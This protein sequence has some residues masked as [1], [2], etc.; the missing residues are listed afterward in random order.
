MAVLNG[1]L[2][3]GWVDSQ[4]TDTGVFT[5]S[6]TPTQLWFP[7]LVNNMQNGGLYETSGCVPDEVRAADASG[8]PSF[9]ASSTTVTLSAT[10]LN[11][12][13]DSLCTQA[14]PGNQVTIAPGDSGAHFFFMVT[15]GNVFTISGSATGL[16]GTQSVSNP[17]DDVWVGGA[18]CDGNWNTNACWSKNNKPQAYQTA[19][20]SGALCSTQ[21]SAAINTNNLNGMNNILLESDYTG[22]VTQVNG[23]S[24]TINGLLEVDGGTF[25]MSTSSSDSFTMNSLLVAGTGTFN[26]GSGT[27]NLNN[28]FVQS[29]GS[30]TSTSGTLSVDGNFTIVGSPTFNANSGTMNFS[31]SQNFASPTA[32]P[33]SI[34]LNN[35]VFSGQNWTTLTISGTM[36]VIGSLTESVS[37]LGGNVNGGTVALVGGGTQTISDTT[38]AGMGGGNVTI[39]INNTGTVTASTGFGSGYLTMQAG[40]FSGGSGTI[41][42][43]KDFSLSG[44]SFT[45]TSGTFNAGGS[46]TV[47]GSP[48]FNANGGT[49]AFSTVQSNGNVTLTPGSISLNNV[50]FNGDSWTS[51][52]IT[53]TLNVAGDATI[54][55][56]SCCSGAVTGGTLSVAGNFT[57][58][59]NTG[60]TTALT[61]TGGGAQTLT[62]TAGTFLSGNI[63]VNKTAGSTL[64]LSG[65]LALATA[66]ALNITSG[67]FNLNGNSITKV[68]SVTIGDTL[69]M[70]SGSITTRGS[71]TNNGTFNAG[72]GTVTFSGSGAPTIGGTSAT[73]FNNVTFNKSGV[74][75][76]LGN[77]ITATGNV[78]ITAGTLA[79]AGYG[80]T[81]YG[82][83]NNAGTFTP[84]GDTVTLPSGSGITRTIVGSTTFYNLTMDDSGDTFSDVLIFPAG[85]TQTVTNALVLK[86]NASHN[87]KIRSSTPGT[88]WK[89]NPQ[90]TST[91]SDVDVQDSDNINATAITADSASVDAGNN[92]NWTFPS[93]ITWIGGTVGTNGCDGN[94]TTTSCWAGGVLPGATTTAVFKSGCTSNCSPTLNANITVGGILMTSSYTGTLTQQGANTLTINQDFGQYAGTFTGGSAGLTE[95]GH[96]TLAGGTFTDTITF[97]GSQT[98]L[99]SI[100]GGTLSA[101]S[102]ITVNKAV[103][104]VLRLLNNVTL[105]GQTVNILSGIFNSYGHNLTGT[106]NLTITDTLQVQGGETFTTASTTFNSVSTV[107]YN[108]SGNYS[109]NNLILGNAYSNLT[110]AGGQA[111]QWAFTAAT[112][113]SGNLTITSGTLIQGTNSLLTVGGNWSNSATFNWGALQGT[114][115]TGNGSQTIGG[116]SPTTFNGIAFSGT[117][118]Y[119]QN[120]AMSA[121][122]GLIIGGTSTLNSNGFGLTAGSNIANYG[123]YVSGGNTVTLATGFSNFY[124]NSISFYN[125]V[126]DDSGGSAADSITFAQGDTYTVTNSLVLKGNA[127]NKLKLRS[128]TNGIQWNLIPPA[129]TTVGPY[130]DVKD[131][132]SSVTI[133]SGANNT[134]SGN[135]VN[136]SFP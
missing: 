71:W 103:G 11:F 33:G 81:V 134:N 31:T 102:T 19:V 1:K 47:S 82:I 23:K 136:W 27:I 16:S 73:T 28:Y 77:S 24:P 86:G 18:S 78:T 51:V 65:S 26:G 119:T 38:G 123:T 17:D 115:F 39:L 57:M 131:S 45:S 88:Q 63:T 22:T 99:F 46:F 41:N 110:F 126:M 76:T 98:Q 89:I 53:G 92:T 95:A 113:V 120:V 4:F 48:A 69:T 12:Y 35:V 36:N 61:F 135:N 94:W 37:I 107:V 30:F 74:T 130:I 52:Q 49:M 106:A 116:S 6:T 54:A 42:L 108:G 43:N 97:S 122:S 117:G 125:L 91:I 62:Y 55:T 40:T 64:T 68:G 104:S 44:G 85:A 21:C 72:S 32:I 58:T 70:G 109:G 90:G 132:D 14:L 112:T 118:T 100:T 67:T 101:S 7:N 128:S 13:S 20:F 84:G 105:S 127:T 87:L 29:G 80:I 8:H 59:S 121:V 114:T 25:R 66:Q 79:A 9:V 2:Y 34:T 56:S 96:F 5:Q 133:H 111:A 15:T 93:D 129:G 60:G 3:A 83:W 75:F 10:G 124:G 50:I